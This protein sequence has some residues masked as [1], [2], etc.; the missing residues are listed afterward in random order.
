MTYLAVWLREVLYRTNQHRDMFSIIALVRLTVYL[1]HRSK[2]CLSQN[3]KLTCDTLKTTK[4]RFEMLW[5]APHFKRNLFHYFAGAH[6]P[7]RL[8]IKA[9]ISLDVSH[10][11][12]CR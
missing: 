5:S 12:S 3:E 2:S 9:Q 7:L 10:G 8:G 4:L 6:D 1:R 11:E